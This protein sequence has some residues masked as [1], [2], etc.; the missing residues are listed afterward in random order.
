MTKPALH[1]GPLVISV[2]LSYN[3]SPS[4]Y[5]FFIMRYHHVKDTGYIFSLNPIQLSHFPFKRMRC[6]QYIRHPVQLHPPN[7]FSVNVYGAVIYLMLK[8]HSNRSKIV[9]CPDDFLCDL[10]ICYVY[11]RSLNVLSIYL[12]TY[13]TT[14]MH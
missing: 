5:T 4:F 13:S 2:Y 10:K 3:F 12:P 7:L 14:H 11:T 9:Q 1:C 8:S 6:I